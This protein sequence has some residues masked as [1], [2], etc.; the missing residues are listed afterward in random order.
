MKFK[1]L[2]ASGLT[3]ASRP[4]TFTETEFFMQQIAKYR[5]VDTTIL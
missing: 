1:S 2:A 5:V 4:V 3:F